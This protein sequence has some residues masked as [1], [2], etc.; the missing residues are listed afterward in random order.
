MSSDSSAFVD[1]TSSPC[2]FLHSA[3]RG[4]PATVSNVELADPSLDLA[5]VRAS[6]S[7][8]QQAIDQTEALRELRSDHEVLRREHKYEVVHHQLDSTRKELAD[9]LNA[10]EE[11][12]DNSR[13]LEAC[14]LRYHDLQLR[15]DEAVSE[16]QDRISTLEAQQAAASSFG[17]IVPPDTARRLTDLGSQLARSHSDLL[18]ARDRQSSLASEL[19]ESATSHKAAQAEVD[20]LEAVIERKTRRFRTMREN[21]ERRLKDRVSTLDRDLQKASQRVRTAISQR[22]QARAERIATQ[23][24]V[25]AARDTI[26]RFEKR[27]NQVEKS[28]KS[29][30]ESGALSDC[31]ES[32]SG[33][34][35]STRVF[36]SDTAGSD[37]GSPELSRAR[38][39]FGMPSGHLSDAELHLPRFPDRS[40]FPVI[41][42]AVTSAATISSPADGMANPLRCSAP[43]HGEWRD[44]LVDE[45]NVRDLIESA[46]WEILAAKIDPL[47]SEVE[48]NSDT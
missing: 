18:V 2:S 4:G 42:V 3:A 25:S 6:L 36:D 8:Q 47:T 7:T 11:R 13:E 26:A 19:R 45:S 5:S 44:D 46:P 39:Q 12:L 37:S 29:P 43:P 24:R 32:S 41:V 10:L 31:G 27:I 22:D 15:Y 14:R 35:S 33:K 30:S 9:C 48:V 20:R 28:Q 34:S 21:Y 40:G 17:V 16:F 23:D 38:D 1:L